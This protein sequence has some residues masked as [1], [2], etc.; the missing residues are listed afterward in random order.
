MDPYQQVASALKKHLRAQKI[1]QARLAE[2]MHIPESTLKKW[3]NAKDGSFNRLDRVCRALGLSLAAV[4]KS[5]ERQEVEILEFTEAQQT[6]FKQNPEIF[7]AY[8]FLV[9]E[10]QG[11]EGTGHALGIKVET[12][13]RACLQMDKLGLLDVLPGDRLQLPEPR[14]IRWRPKGA[15]IERVFRDWSMGVLGEA[16]EQKN[17]LILQFFQLSEEGAAEFQRDL[18]RLEER[19]ARRTIQDMGSQA[20][21]PKKIRFLA[22]S[23]EGSFFKPR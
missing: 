7:K 1:P 13:K 23:G 4:M 10:R 22:A 15:F 14:P 8:W 21:A 20:G 12:L 11:L 6:Y 18:K 9:Y 17:D 3:L 16:L 5:I 2:R 19:Y